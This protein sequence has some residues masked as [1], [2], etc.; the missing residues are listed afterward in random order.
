MYTDLVEIPIIKT[1][2]C[3]WLEYKKVSDQE[4]K[5]MEWWTITDWWTFNTKENIVKDFSKSRGSGWNLNFVMEY[6]NCDQKEAIE[7]FH[8]KWLLEKKKSVSDI[9]VTLPWLS[10]QQQTYLKWRGI[11]PDKVKDFTKN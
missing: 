11:N 5:L 2:D 1:I 3:L 6:L 7:W 4:Y 8:E 10:E 9:R